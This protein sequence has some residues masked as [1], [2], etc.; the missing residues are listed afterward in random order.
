[1][2]VNI[3]DKYRG[4][5]STSGGIS[6]SEELKIAS[7]TFENYVSGTIL[8]VFFCTFSFVQAVG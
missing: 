2:S 3:G 4:G 5:Y 1:M 6:S 7:S 8:L